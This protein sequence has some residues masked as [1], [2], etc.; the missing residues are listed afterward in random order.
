MRV[1]ALELEKP[2]DDDNWITVDNLPICIGN[3]HFAYE[4]FS[5]MPLDFSKDDPGSLM[6]E[7]DVSAREL[8]T[9]RCRINLNG[10][11]EIQQGNVVAFV[12]PPKQGKSTLLKILGGEILAV[13]AGI[14]AKSFVPSH[15]RLLHVPAEPHFFDGSLS[16]NL[17]FGSTSGDIDSRKQRVRA[18]LERLGLTEDVTAHLDSDASHDWPALF[19]TTEVHLLNIG[20]A[21]V[22]NP[23]ILCIHKPTL[24]FNKSTSQRVMATFK[25]YVEQKGVQQDP[26][27]WH[28]RRP[29]TCIFTSATIVGIEQYVDEAFYVDGVNGIQRISKDQSGSHKEAEFQRGSG[30]FVTHSENSNPIDIAAR[31]KGASQSRSAGDPKN[32]VTPGEPRADAFGSGSD[33]DSEQSAPSLTEEETVYSMERRESL[34]AF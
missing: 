5:K 16:E 15:L 22:A 32:A 10:V 3:V 28:H 7:R 4:T 19:S 12:G 23:E 14:R 1:N 9:R 34:G 31:P 17:I 27:E 8:S 21:L 24:V 29:R 6:S 2:G 30:R 11:A 26:N 33:S 18:I 25:E 13:G 20:R